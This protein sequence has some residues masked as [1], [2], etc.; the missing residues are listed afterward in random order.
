[1]LPS[2]T[3][4]AA[5]ERPT[6]GFW[7]QRQRT[8][9]DH[10]GHLGDTAEEHLEKWKEEHGGVGLGLVSAAGMQLCP[11]EDC[12]HGECHDASLQAGVG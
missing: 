7:D 2:S 4:E 11:Q 8:G 10:E 1:M 5:A 6:S 9:T 12:A 3:L